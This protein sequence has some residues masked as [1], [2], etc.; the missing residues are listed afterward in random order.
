MRILA[1]GDALLPAKYVEDGLARFV[2]RGDEITVASWGE[3]DEEIIDRRAR[4]LELNGPTADSPPAEIE[5]IIAET[6][7]FTEISSYSS[8]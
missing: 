7:Y 5:Q 4:N 6:F 3:D 8:H 1:V 2:K